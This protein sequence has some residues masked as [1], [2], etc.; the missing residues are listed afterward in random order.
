MEVSAG[1]FA[2]S[3]CDDVD[4]DDERPIG[5]KGQMEGPIQASAAR[6][7][8]CRCIFRPELLASTKFSL[9]NIIR[10]MCA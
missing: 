1:Q 7:R 4:V 2:W 3:C 10:H 8:P 6:E 5:R 9:T